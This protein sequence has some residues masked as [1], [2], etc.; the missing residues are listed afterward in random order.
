MARCAQAGQ[1]G[2]EAITLDG[3]YA[4]EL[5]LQILP[6]LVFR[7]QN[8]VRANVG[9]RLGVKCYADSQAHPISAGT[10]PSRGFPAK[11]SSA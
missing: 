1:A 7:H 10:A 4:V 8:C 11:S 3:C 6:V 2:E 5:N 9:S